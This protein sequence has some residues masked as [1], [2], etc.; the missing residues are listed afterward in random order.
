MNV[1]KK[2]KKKVSIFIYYSFRFKNRLTIYI[3]FILLLLLCII[4]I[5]F[6]FKAIKENNSLKEIIVTQMIPLETGETRMTVSPL[7]YTT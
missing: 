4:I 1:E 5:F 3:Y 2:R 7:I 6:F